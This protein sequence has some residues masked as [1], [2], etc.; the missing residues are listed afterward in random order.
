MDRQ[1]VTRATSRQE[2]THWNEVQRRQDIKSAKPQM[3]ASDYIISVAKFANCK[4]RKMQNLQNA[5]FVKCKICKTQNYPIST[6][7]WRLG[8]LL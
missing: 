5:K 1:Y 8:H 2:S 7:A 3:H 6:R 4:I